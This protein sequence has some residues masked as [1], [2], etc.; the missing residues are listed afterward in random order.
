LVK[1]KKNSESRKGPVMERKGSIRCRLRKKKV[2]LEKTTRSMHKRKLEF[3][4]REDITTGE[5]W[6]G[7]GVGGRSTIKGLN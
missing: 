3:C 2:V 7:T 6:N 5:S 4:R 1:R